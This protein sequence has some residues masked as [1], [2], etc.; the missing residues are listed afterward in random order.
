LAINVKRPRSEGSD[1]AVV[2]G[3][4]DWGADSW[5]YK[6]ENAEL[7]I[8]LDEVL[9]AGTVTVLSSAQTDDAEIDFIEEQVDASDDRFMGGL[10]TYL[11]KN[12]EMWIEVTE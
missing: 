5:D 9:T 11:A 1:F 8:L 7:T 10:S 6:T 12:S 3:T 2:V 4:V